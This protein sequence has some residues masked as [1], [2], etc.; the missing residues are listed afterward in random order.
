[1]KILS[2]DDSRIVRKIIKTTVEVLGHEVIEAEDALEAFA[3]LEENENYN[4]VDL[5]LLDWNLPGMS[6][7]EM[8]RELK[9]DER[10]EHIPV[11]MVTSEIERSNVAMAVN[12]GAADYLTKPFSSEELL[13]KIMEC[14]EL[15]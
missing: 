12:A 6:G 1:M 9:S 2:V 8:L 10:F 15:A 14:G 4:E 11:I 5:I 3:Y 13:V 7:Y